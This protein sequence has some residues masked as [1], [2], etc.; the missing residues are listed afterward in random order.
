MGERMTEPILSPLIQFK[1]PPEAMR[2]AFPRIRD[3]ALAAMGDKWHREMLQDHFSQV[4]YTKYG[5]QKRRKEY[6]KRKRKK[7]GHNDPM[8]LKGTL[9]QSIR[10]MARI[11]TSSK[12]V[13][14]T[15]SGAQ[16]NFATKARVAKGYPDFRAEI[17]AITPQQAQTLAEF[18]GA[19]MAQELENIS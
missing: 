1:E 6:V 18:A 7:Y 15:M 3:N 2:K 4:A 12:K 5:F 19:R 17:T 11:S 14:I 10:S 13:R 8:R 16:L 9:E